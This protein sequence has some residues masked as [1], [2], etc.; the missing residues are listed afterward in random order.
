MKMTSNPGRP[1]SHNNHARFKPKI[2]LTECLF[3]QKYPVQQEVDRWNESNFF[4]LE[5]N[6]SIQSRARALNF[7]HRAHWAEF[8]FFKKPVF[9]VFSLYI[10]ILFTDHSVKASLVLHLKLI[11]LI[12]KRFNKEKSAG[13]RL[14][15]AVKSSAEL[16]K[17]RSRH[18]RAESL[19]TMR[20]K[21]GP[22]LRARAEAGSTSS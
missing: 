16:F 5:V 21:W 9:E 18:F 2:G 1:L 7:Y 19:L 17:F 11:F 14:A 4:E 6:L 20:Q 8:C 22:G 3:L 15:S 10:H 13:F 12:Y